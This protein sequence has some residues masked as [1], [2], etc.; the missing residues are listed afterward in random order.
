M[1]TGHTLG[2]GV[3]NVSDGC[4]DVTHQYPQGQIGTNGAQRPLRRTEAAAATAPASAPAAAAVG[5]PTFT[6]LRP[7]R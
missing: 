2:P 3:T 7:V 1:W 5:T 6:A 4:P